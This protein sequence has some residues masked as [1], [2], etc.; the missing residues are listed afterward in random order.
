M[1]G[2][3]GLVRP[4]GSR[5][6]LSGGF[7]EPPSEAFTVPAETIVSVMVNALILI[8]QAQHLAP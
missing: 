4:S 3:A 5:A 2:R 6:A 7:I 8:R 1:M